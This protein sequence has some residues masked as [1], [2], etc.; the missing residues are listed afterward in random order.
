MSFKLKN[1]VEKR[2]LLDVEM[3]GEGEDVK[4]YKYLIPRVK[5]YKAM[6][7]NTARLKIAGA[8]GKSV[9]GSVVVMDIVERAQTV[10]GD[11]S[12]YELLMALDADNSDAL[13]EEVVR[14][15]TTG[16]AK[17]MAEGAEIREVEL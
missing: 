16:I 10:E 9:T 3:P 2:V 12:L 4:H 15:A 6:E 13:M 7:A 1:Q 17:L 14:L 8:D 5:Q 11:L